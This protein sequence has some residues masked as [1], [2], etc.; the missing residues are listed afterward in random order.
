MTFYMDY[1]KYYAIKYRFHL[2]QIICIL[3]SIIIIALRNTTFEK[4]FISVKFFY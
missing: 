2:N 1:S 4:C 3:L